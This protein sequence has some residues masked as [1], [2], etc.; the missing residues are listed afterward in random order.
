MVYE[1]VKRAF[2]HVSFLK[3]T[4]IFTH[5]W[6]MLFNSVLNRWNINHCNTSI[7]WLEGIRVS[8]I[9]LSLLELKRLNEV[10]NIKG[11]DQ[12]EEERKT[13]CRLLSGQMAAKLLEPIG[14]TKWICLFFHIFSFMSFVLHTVFLS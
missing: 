2:L 13:S 7:I 10:V 9:D 5:N 14:L 3:I 6:R 1:Q 8:Y 4:L 12:T 11:R